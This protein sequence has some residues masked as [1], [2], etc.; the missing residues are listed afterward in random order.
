LLQQLLFG[1][2]VPGD[3]QFV[4]RGRSGLF[5]IASRNK[6]GAKRE[7]AYMSMYRLIIIQNRM[8]GC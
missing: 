6:H 2:P 8:L 1:G 5:L 4:F 7:D 3:Q